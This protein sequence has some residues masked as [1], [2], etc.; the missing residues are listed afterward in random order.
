MSVKADNARIQEAMRG[1]AAERDAARE[2]AHEGMHRHLQRA[3][4]EEGRRSANCMRCG[5]RIEPEAQP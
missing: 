4:N 2:A 3:A 1:K 5:Q